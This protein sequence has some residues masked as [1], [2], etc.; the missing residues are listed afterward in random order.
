MSLFS[1]VA[2]RAGIADAEP[3]P[4]ATP[5]GLAGMGLFRA[6]AEPEAHEKEE[7]EVAPLRRISQ[8][9]DEEP[10]RPLRRAAARPEEKEEGEEMAPLRRAA[11]GEEDEDEVRPAPV[12]RAAT[13]EAD[14]PITALRRTLPDE[15]EPALQ[16]MRRAV[17]EEE[18]GKAGEVAALRRTGEPMEE[19]E[20]AAPLRRAFPPDAE[21]L[22]AETSPRPPTSGAEEE[23]PGLRMLRREA[24]TL[25]AGP[26]TGDTSGPAGPGVSSAGPEPAPAFVPIVETG[27]PRPA[28]AGLAS[29]ERPRVVIEHIDVQVH[30]PAAQARGWTPDLGRALRARYLGG[31]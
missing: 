7:E 13:E 18:E 15:D 23:L 31:F 28:P 1:R 14:E 11:R 5:K 9:P 25:N 17:N 27:P 3:A 21:T 20:I 8:L 2:A 12:R 10:V 24:A 29:A 4:L 22:D 26:A 16:P 30:E 6:A 19:E